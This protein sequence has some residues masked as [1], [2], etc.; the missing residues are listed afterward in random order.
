MQRKNWAKNADG[1]LK[2]LYMQVREGDVEVTVR[3]GKER[4][5]VSVRVCIP[6]A[7]W[8]RE[9]GKEGGRRRKWRER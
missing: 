7:G 4:L 6:R 5:C 2:K 3:K 1:R 8:V 9:G